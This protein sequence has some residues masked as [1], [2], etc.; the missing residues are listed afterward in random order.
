MLKRIILRDSESTGWRCFDEPVR[1]LVAHAVEEVRSVLAE[2]QRAVDMD[3]LIAAGFVSY[4]AAP[5]FDRSLRTRENG[6][7]PLAAFGL[8]SGFQPLQRLPAAPADAPAHDWRLTTSRDAYGQ[9]IRAVREQIALGNCYQVNFTIRKRSTGIGDPWPL[10][11]QIAHSARF[12][13]FLEFDDFAI[14]S[15]SPELFFALDGSHIRCRPMKGTARRGMTTASDDAI[16]MALQV[17]EKNRAENV[18]IADMIRNDLGRIAIPGTVRALALCELEKYPTV[19]QLTSTIEARTHAAV[20]AIFTALFPCASVTGAPK[21]AAMGLIA[22]MEDTPREVYSGAIGWIAPGRKAQ[23][24]VAIRTAVI[25]RLDG[26]ATYGVGGGIVWDSDPDDEYQECEAKARVLELPDDP[27]GTFELLETFR[28]TPGE[29]YFLRDFHLDRMLDSARYFDFKLDRSYVDSVLDAAAI[30]FEAPMRVRLKVDRGGECRMDAGPL[31]E[32][33]ARDWRLRLARYPVDDRNPFLYHKTTQ[34][35]VYAA[36]AMDVGPCDDVLL[37]N[38]AG[39]ITE[40]TRANIVV[41]L[42]GRDF[43]PAVSNGLLAGTFRRWL[44]ENTDLEERDIAVSDLARAESIV[45]VN[46][47][48]GQVPASVLTVDAA[49]Q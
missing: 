26:A 34:R 19:W 33:G 25:D 27:G 14:A 48:R 18:M 40:T 43:T 44:L 47:V 45:V 11:L 31:T 5:A 49:G 36:A 29:G 9:S 39:C 3:G 10:F 35:R 24:S 6:R 37:W 23:F 15:A 46:S 4:E 13:A 1:M 41:R 38:S 30:G 17:S 16:A 21:T 28:W 42:Q 22:R 12:G 7:L 32:T 2:A 20:D 8:F